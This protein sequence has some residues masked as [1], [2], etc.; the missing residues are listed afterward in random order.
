MSSGTFVAIVAAVFIMAQ[1]ALI[2]RF[3]LPPYFLWAV[4]AAVGSATVL[5]YSIL[6]EYFPKEL[7]G[8][9][10]AALNVFHIAGAF[11]VQYGIGV[12]LQF[13]TPQDGHYPEI[14]FQCAFGINIGI[15]LVTWAWF[16]LPQIRRSASTP[17]GP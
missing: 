16:A 6:A 5:S 10:N 9:A 14:A 1:L 3:P 8:R 17:R 15:Q 4:V 12:V 7:V 11:I 2:A 13:W